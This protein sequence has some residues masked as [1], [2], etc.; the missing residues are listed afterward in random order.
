M[1]RFFVGYDTN[2][3]GFDFLPKTIDSFPFNEEELEETINM[4]VN[5]CEIDIKDIC[6]FELSELN[7]KNFLKQPNENQS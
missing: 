1:G 2:G 4:A 6:I 3:K 7:P 5:D